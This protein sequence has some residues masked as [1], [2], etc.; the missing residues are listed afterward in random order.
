MFLT[1]NP[2]KAYQILYLLLISLF[3]IFGFRLITRIDKLSFYWPESR[4]FSKIFSIFNSATMETDT[5]QL[6]WSTRPILSLLTEWKFWLLSVIGAGNSV[7]EPDEKLRT[8]VMCNITSHYFSFGTFIAGLATIVYSNRAD[9]LLELFGAFVYASITMIL[10]HM[11]LP[12][13]LLVTTIIGFASVI[14]ISAAWNLY[15]LYMLNIHMAYHEDIPTES[16]YI[17]VIFAGQI[18]SFFIST[19]LCSNA[20]SP[21]VVIFILIVMHLTI[22]FLS[23]LDYIDLNFVHEHNSMSLLAARQNKAY[24]AV[25]AVSAAASMLQHIL[26]IF[27][28]QSRIFNKHGGYA[29]VFSSCALAPWM[30]LV[31]NAPFYYQLAAIAI[32]LLLLVCM[33]VY[34]VTLFGFFTLC[35]F[36][37]ATM[38]LCRS[39]YGNIAEKRISSYF[40]LNYMFLVNFVLAVSVLAYRYLDIH[41]GFFVMNLL[42]KLLFWRFCTEKSVQQQIQM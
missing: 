27:M 25:C 21:L 3:Y 8:L 41:N 9:K 7:L 19:A 38:Q 35:V 40:S 39:F 23:R 34:S 1:N 15:F 17:K 31:Y 32:F 11:A 20:V 5:V 10:T 26:Y 22:L 42:I 13:D 4:F 28:G 6:I 12:P 33:N 14:L 36:I 24:Y 29:S 18:I 30:F 2:F 16:K 37:F